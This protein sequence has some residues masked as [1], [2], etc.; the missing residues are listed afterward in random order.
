[1]IRA[2]SI[3]GSTKLRM[4]G[5]SDGIVPETDNL[6][7]YVCARGHKMT[8]LE[9]DADADFEAFAATVRSR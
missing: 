7:E 5:L 1:M 4:P 8:P 9:F 2:C 6:A 3:C